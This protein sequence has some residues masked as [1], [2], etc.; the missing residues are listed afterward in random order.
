M[1]VQRL[2]HQGETSSERVKAFTEGNKCFIG[3]GSEK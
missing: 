3:L 2:E 1:K